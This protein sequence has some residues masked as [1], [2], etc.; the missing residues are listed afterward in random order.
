MKRYYVIY[1]KNL[2]KVVLLKSS[3]NNYLWLYLWAHPTIRNTKDVNNLIINVISSVKGTHHVHFFPKIRSLKQVAR[4]QKWK[5]K[6]W[7]CLFE[8]CISYIHK[9]RTYKKFDANF[10]IQKTRPKMESYSGT[11]E[12]KIVEEVFLKFLT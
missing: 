7:S 1:R 2:F 5:Y 8:D 12:V 10:R 4:T 3:N 11:Q 6:G 9:S